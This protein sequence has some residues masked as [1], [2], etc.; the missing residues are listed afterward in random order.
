MDI[1]VTTP[2]GDADIDIVAAPAETTL[3]DLLRAVTGQASPAT[4]RL[5]E[6]AVSTA[7]LLTD[8]DLAIG[9][10]IDTRPA[11][12]LDDLDSG[13]G[14]A[15]SSPVVQLM[16]LTGRGAGTTRSLPSGR[17]LVGTAR[18]PRGDELDTAPVDTAAFELDVGTDGSVRVSPTVHI[19]GARGID[20]PTLDGRLLDRELPW[21]D[22]QL[23]VGGRRFEL[24][25]HPAALPPGRR[26]TPLPDGTI[27]FRRGAAVPDSDRRLVVGAVRDATTGGGQLWQWRPGDRGA[28]DIAYGLHRDGSSIASADLL[29]HGGVAVVGSERFAA[30]L[31]RTLLIE[32]CTMHG[33]STLDLAIAST[34][35]RIERWNWAR[36]LPHLRSGQPNSPAQLW[37]EPD[38]LRA[39]ADSMAERPSDSAPRRMTML[40]VDD[41]SLWSRRDSPLQNLLTD[42]PKNFRLIGLC[43]DIDEAP[44]VCSERIVEVGPAQRLATTPTDRGEAPAVV[45]ELFGSFATHRSLDGRSAAS[46]DDISPAL[47]EERLAAEVARQLAP[48]DDLDRPHG[49]NPARATDI[50]P[51]TLASVV[52]ASAARVDD[53]SRLSVVVGTAEMVGAV[54]G[55]QRDLAVE[56]SGPLSTIVTAAGTEQHDLAVAAVVLGAATQRRPDELAVVILGQERREWYDQLPHVVG[57]VGYSEADDPARLLHRIAHV[58]AARPELHVLIVV[59]HAFHSDDPPAPELVAAMNE[60]AVTH[61]NVHVVWSGDH[62]GSVPAYA[63]SSCGALVWFTPRGDG[64]VWF[65]ERSFSFVG[66]AATALSELTTTDADDLIVRPSAVSRSLTSLERRLDRTGDGNQASWASRVISTIARR[67]GA[68]YGGPDAQRRVAT[69][70][71]PPPLATT[72]DAMQLLDDHPGDAIPIGLI[73]RPELARHEPFW[74]QPGSEGSILTV[75]SPRSAMNSLIDVLT[76]GIAARFA[77]DDLHVYA[78]ETAGA[79]RRAIEALPHTGGVADPDRTDE[80]V[81][82]VA[83]LRSILSQ[84]LQRPTDLDRPD[85]IVVISD[86]GRMRRSL[87]PEQDDTT[88][89]QL[90]ELVAS[91][92]WVGLNVVIGATKVDELG[93]LDRLTGNRLVGPMSDPDDRSR[94]GVAAVDA[95]DRH[96]RRCWSTAEDR[97]VQLATPPTDLERRITALA[98]EPPRYRP[99]SP[100]ATGNES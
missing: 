69:A 76:L 32:V 84:R 88:I 13:T 11:S 56:L 72:V 41:E 92:A 27:P 59:E 60:L 24:L 42:A 77:A 53:G 25:R 31:A 81:A 22:G 46:T 49:Q 18:S 16:Q 91:G 54:P 45:P 86:L 26:S 67:V 74:W 87:T 95:A 64:T 57:W 63:R 28:Y 51:P 71:V 33:P 83:E 1:V 20:A 12:P 82:L 85:I 14:D 35:E 98:P 34:P 3:A 8:L 7:R 75:G 29:H 39:W 52:D 44:A 5:D 89:E 47:V 48:L 50:T 19:V 62:P 40:V 93:P 30:A 97:R 2:H 17:F 65:P 10:T 58:V 43:D 9:S 100:I 4:A 70:L 90:G 55:A 96:P 94:L 79:R 61:H 99:P 80:I 78:I 73:D 23:H 21:A 38:Q 37:S 66:P 15:S 6:R 36:W 68:R